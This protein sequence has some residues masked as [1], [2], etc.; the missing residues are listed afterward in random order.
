M[1]RD[2]IY[3]IR[4]VILYVGLAFVIFVCIYNFFFADQ[5]EKN[6]RQENIKRQFKGKVLGKDDHHVSKI[7]MLI[8][9]KEETIYWPHRTFYDSVSIGDN[10][11]KIGNEDSV[12]IEN[13]NSKLKFPYLHTEKS[14]NDPLFE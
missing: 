12:I 13:K 1:K 10:I 7:Y 5:V 9:G 4:A 14:H 6:E 2:Y 8:E 3:N 11:V